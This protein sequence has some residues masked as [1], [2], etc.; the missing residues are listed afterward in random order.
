[1]SDTPH[2]RLLHMFLPGECCFFHEL[3]VHGGTRLEFIAIAS[4]SIRKTTELRL[5]NFDRKK[6]LRPG[7]HGMRRHEGSYLRHTIYAKLIECL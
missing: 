6:V 2:N 5:A 1:M 4:V 7:Q 3:I